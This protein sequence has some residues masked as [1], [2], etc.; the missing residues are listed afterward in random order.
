MVLKKIL[1][2]CRFLQSSVNMLEDVSDFFLEFTVQLIGSNSII[3]LISVD[4]AIEVFRTMNTDRPSV[5]LVTCIFRLF[6]G[7]NHQS[8]WLVMAVSKYATTEHGGGGEKRANKIHFRRARPLQC[9][10]DW[11]M[12]RLSSLSSK[13]G[14]KIQRQKKIIIIKKQGKEKS[15]TTSCNQFYLC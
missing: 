14:W 6:R 10:V 12:Q 5:P 11:Q 13:E 15:M 9:Y 8:Y 1:K 4:A 3:Q 2:I 7:R